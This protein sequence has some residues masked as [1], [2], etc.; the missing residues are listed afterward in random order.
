MMLLL[1]AGSSTGWAETW[2]NY[3]G[4]EGWKFINLAVFITAGII[5][6]RRPLRD[7]LVARQERIRLQLAEAEKERDAAQARLTEAEAMVAR[8][9]T[10]VA[11]LRAQAKNEAQMERR[12]LSEATDKEIEKMRTQ[13][14]RE[15]ETAGKVARK[16]L[17][18]FLAHRSVELAREAVRT[19]IRPDDDSRLIQEGIGQLRRTGA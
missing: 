14:E 6:L 8:I 13:A 9:D 11:T 16:E 15:I 19:Q 1:L 10:D 17:Q 5:I 3:P 7:A 12:R 2:L 4:L 18:K